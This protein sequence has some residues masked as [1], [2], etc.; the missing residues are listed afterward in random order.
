MTTALHFFP[1]TRHD[2]LVPN[3]KRPTGPRCVVAKAAQFFEKGAIKAFAEILPKRD[4]SSFVANVLRR[5]SH[6][7]K[8]PI[9]CDRLQRIVSCTDALLSGVHDKQ[10]LRYHAAFLISL[11]AEMM[12]LQPPR[13]VHQNPWFARAF[14]IDK[15]KNR[16][17]ILSKKQSIRTAWG[18]N[19]KMS[20]AT[21]LFLDDF[22]TQ[23]AIRLTNRSRKGIPPEIL[24]LNVDRMHLEIDLGIEVNNDVYVKVEHT[25][26]RGE[27]KLTWVETEYQYTLLEMLHAAQEL[28]EA[29]ELSLL[30]QIVEKLHLKL[31]AAGI[32]HQDIKPE[33]V[34]VTVEPDGTIKAKL[35]D[36]GWSYDLIHR[37]N[38][39]VGHCDG[40]CTPAYTSPERL[41][42][43]KLLT[44][45]IEQGKADDMYAFGCLLYMLIFKR[46]GSWFDKVSAAIATQNRA[47]YPSLYNMQ[48][49]AHIGIKFAAMVA[50]NSHRKKLTELCR[51]LLDPNPHTRLTI[52]QVI[53]RLGKN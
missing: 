30:Q 13:Y 8:A 35:T 34:L 20:G 16:L 24:R 52:G 45:P 33:N 38:Y 21:I 10:P 18:A 26:K 11:A 22:R 40:Y 39:Y 19:K 4:T 5:I 51:D 25:N 36:F 17:I 15:L 53:L 27:P 50:L 46:M 2:Y 47:Q 29:Q 12:P 42:P 14:V 31:H 28:T 48:V 3:E 49:Q 6:S 41:C 9:A 37:L 23:R 44:D 32:V 7:A 43:E 1:Y